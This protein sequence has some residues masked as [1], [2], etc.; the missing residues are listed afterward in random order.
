MSR[1]NEAADVCI[2]DIKAEEREYAVDP[3]A[4]FNEILNKQNAEL[5]KY[6]K[7]KTYGVK[8]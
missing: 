4:R 6:I 8:G 2:D 7:M 3:I 5:N 1:V